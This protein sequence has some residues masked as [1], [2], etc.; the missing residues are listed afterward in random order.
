MQLAALGEAAGVA[1]TL[2][3]LPHTSAT[4][5]LRQ[6]GAGLVTVAVLLGHE[7]VAPRALYT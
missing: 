1:V 6:A 2:H 4:R 7:N 3:I 5:L